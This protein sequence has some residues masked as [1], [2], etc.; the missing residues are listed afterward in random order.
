[1]WHM[2]LVTDKIKAVEAHASNISI[3]LPQ[4]DTKVRD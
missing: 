2:A 3:Q 4:N 1:V